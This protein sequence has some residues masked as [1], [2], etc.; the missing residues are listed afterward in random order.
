[1]ESFYDVVEFFQAVAYYG[2][3]HG[4]SP[5]DWPERQLPDGRKWL[6][7]MNWRIDAA[8]WRMDPYVP[9]A[10]S[11]ILSESSLGRMYDSNFISDFGTAKTL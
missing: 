9:L 2:I 7:R 11:E 3:N 5:C 4:C 1:M 6:R 8:G 10:L